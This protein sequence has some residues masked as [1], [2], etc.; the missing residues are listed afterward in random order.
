MVSVDLVASAINGIPSHI[1]ILDAAGSIVE[2]N[3]A[4]RQ[5]AIQN[6]SCD[7]KAYLGMNYLDVCRRSAA[8]GDKLASE[9]IAGITA[10]ISRES[11]RFTQRYPCDAGDTTRW[12]TMTV[13]PVSSGS[14]VVVAHEDVTMLV[15]AEAALAEL[16]RRLTLEEQ[17]RVLAQETEHRAKNLLAVVLAIARQTALQH[18]P[19]AS[20][21]EFTH[22]VEGLAASLRLLSGSDWK[23]VSP[24]ELIQSQLAPFAGSLANRVTIEGPPLLIQATAAQALG[25]AF[26]ELATN[27]LKYGALSEGE[28]RISIQWDIRPGVQEHLFHL[29]W[30]ESGGP[31]VKSPSNAG[32]GYTVTVTAV[33]AATG[34]EVRIE[35]P[36]SGLIWRLTAPLE[37]VTL[38]QSA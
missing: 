38:P 25:M 18:V 16:E 14:G 33:E 13:V 1:A 2:V 31:Q 37:T 35:Y 26:H 19:P 10:V 36:S 15:R 27:S 3:D 24:S 32:F 20:A 28:G 34:G 9:A 11:P 7:P 30:S 29:M 21:K 22:R 8:A 5:F 17:H 12:F 23:G 6:G 4:W